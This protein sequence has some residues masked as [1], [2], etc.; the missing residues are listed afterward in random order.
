MK[1]TMWV[2][3]TLTGFAVAARAAMPAAEQLLPADTLVL[4]KVPDW[5]KTLAWFGDSPQGKLWAHPTMKAFRES[6]VKRFAEEVL[7]PIEKELGLKFSEYKDLVHGQ[8]A[9][10]LTRNRWD[11]KSD[12]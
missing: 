12:N 5:D 4:V 1:R 8:L 7:G 6:F 10:A 9:F 3:L 11:G 2:W